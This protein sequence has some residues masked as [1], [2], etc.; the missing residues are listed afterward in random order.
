MHESGTCAVRAVVLA[1]L[2]L[3]LAELLGVNVEQPL[4]VAAHLAL[5]L[6]YLAEGEHALADDGPGLVR[7]GVVADDLARDHEGGDEEAM[8]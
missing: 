6:V 4:Q 5:H 1:D 3:E 7:V 2:G 8:A